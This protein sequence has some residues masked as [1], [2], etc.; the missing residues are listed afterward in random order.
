MSRGT[1]NDVA[2]PMC[3]VRV[4]SNIIVINV[5]HISWMFQSLYE[6]QYKYV[7]FH[8]VS[9]LFI[10]GT[11]LSSLVASAFIHRHLHSSTYTHECTPK[12]M[13]NSEL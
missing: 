11:T 2:A 9:F 3:F 13:I 5:L 4:P 8:D 1:F 6:Y 7:T 12:V 10:P